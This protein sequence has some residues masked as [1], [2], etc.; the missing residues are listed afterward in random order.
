MSTFVSLL[1]ADDYANAVLD[2]V[3]DVL[4]EDATAT[5]VAARAIAV[6]RLGPCGD[7]SIL[8][9]EPFDPSE[10]PTGFPACVAH[11]T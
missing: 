9:A 10:L 3:E 2:Y 8:S 6:E 4:D 5:G 1:S 11:A 7:P